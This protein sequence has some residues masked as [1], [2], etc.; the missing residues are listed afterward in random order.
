MIFQLL[1]V[2][3]SLLAIISIFVRRAKDGLGVRGTAFWILFWIGVDVVVLFP[4]STT[5][6]ANKLGIGRGVDM[7]VYISILMIFFVLFRLNVKIEG[8]NRQITK[9]VRKNAVDDGKKK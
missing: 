6:L 2:L 3:F 9:I 4:N 5:V 7:V 1:I 8:I